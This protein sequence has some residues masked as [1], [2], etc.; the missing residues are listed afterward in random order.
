MSIEE[1]LLALEL[2]LKDIRLNWSDDLEYT[3]RISKKAKCYLITRSKV[4]HAMKSNQKVNIACD[5]NDRIMRYK[6][7]YRNEM[8]IYRHE[9]IG[10]NLYYIGRVIYHLL[11]VM[12]SFQE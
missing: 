12:I 8:Y 10:G 11:K 3:R 9:G 4:I 5:S 7:L 2:I 1:K 6:L